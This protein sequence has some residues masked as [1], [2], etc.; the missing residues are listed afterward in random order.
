MLARHHVASG[1]IA[2]RILMALSAAA[3]LAA[4]FASYP[5]APQ[6]AGITIGRATWVVAPQPGLNITADLGRI[7]DGK[8]TCQFVISPATFGGKTPAGTGKH[9]LLI[10]YKCGEAGK[11]GQGFDGE[12]VTLTCP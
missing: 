3:S 2:P 1:V 11:N 12:T 10:Q 9:I 4:L 8:P 6:G 5:A 7:C